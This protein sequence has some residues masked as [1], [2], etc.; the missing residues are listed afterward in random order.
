MGN[1]TIQDILPLC[2]KPT[3][4]LG[5]EINTIKKEKDSVKLNISL[6]F[7][8]LYEI[9]TSHFGIQILY[10]ILNNH[11]SI[12][13]ERAFYPGPDMENFLRTEK[14]PFFSLESKRPVNS[15][16]IVGFSLLYE[17]NY[18]NI[19]SILDLSNIPFLA[20][21]RNRSHPLVI[22]GGPCTFNPEPVADIF[23]A[24]VIG[25]G[26]DIIIE[27]SE[28]WI[29]WKEGGGKEKIDLLKLWSGI[30][31]VYIP[32]FFKPVYKNTPEIKNISDYLGMEPQF[33]DYTG[34]KRAIVPDIDIIS[35]PESPIV[36]FG[37]PVHDRLRIEIARGCSR[38]CRFCQAGIIYRPVREK[39]V[40]HILEIAKN[41]IKKTGYDDISLLSLSTGDYSDLTG[42]IRKLMNDCGNQDDYLNHTAISLPSIR[43]DVL[44]PE[45]MTLIKRVRKT[46]FTIAPEAGTDRL[47]KVINKGLTEKEIIDTV[48]NAF[49][50]GWKI[51]KLYFMVGLPTETEEDIQGIV[52][53]VKTLRRIPFGKG[54]KPALNVSVT[55]FI[56]KAHTPFQWVTQLSYEKSQEKIGWLKKNLELHGVQFKWQDP[57]VSLLEGIFARGDRRL[58][59]AL[60][61]AYQKGCKM[62]GW[63]DHFNFDLWKEALADNQ[64]DIY[65]SGISEMNTSD[66]LPWDHIDSLVKKSFFIDEWHKALQSEFTEDCRNGACSGCGICD[67]DTIKPVVFDHHSDQASFSFPETVSASNNTNR[68]G[69][70]ELS[71][72]YTI[73]FSKQDDARFLSHLELVNIVMRAIKRA[74]LPIKF[75]KGF[76][77]LPKISFDDPLPVGTE[78]LEDF[79][80]LVLEKYIDP[81]LILTKMQ[82]E[83]PQGLLF[84]SCRPEIKKGRNHHYNRVRY[85][86]HSKIRPFEEPPLTHFFLQEKFLSAKISKN[87]KKK[88]IDLRSPVL[89]IEFTDSHKLTMVLKSDLNFSVRPSEIIKAIFHFSDTEIKSLRIIKMQAYEHTF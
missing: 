6:I 19:I 10:S 40:D 74:D 66:P 26:E 73:S 48:K 13:A 52:D 36:P 39:S 3:R 21:E 56:P 23:D 28:K 24:M 15:F 76:H 12:A 80:Y 71:F 54:R 32:S 27:M 86:I 11:P 58:T 83:L 38:G 31:G 57:K 88:E 30:Q 37:K 81:D 68:S 1:L 35:T 8:D 29:S 53:L 7:P 9:G 87:G 46:G 70:L 43:A 79:L 72:N 25:D 49:E 20:S 5:C 67:F 75:S 59:P 17:L 45:L 2:E 82:N 22:A 64:Y 63:R 55:S 47:R 34:V 41:G 18:T 42:L 62:D 61:S 16:D 77:P 69:N 78:T 89:N 50:L 33:P 14:I 85:M 44:S 60:I 65:Q 84:H 51:I 4:Y